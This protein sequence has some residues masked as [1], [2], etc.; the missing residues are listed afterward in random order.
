M[1]NFFNNVYFGNSIK[2]WTTALSILLLGVLITLFFKKR[3]LTCLKRW[4]S[5]SQT[6]LDDFLLATIETSVVPLFYVG[7]FSVAIKALSIPAGIGAV[8]HVAVLLFST[9]FV[10]KVITSIARQFVFSFIKSEDSDQIQAKQARGLILIINIVLWILGIIFL[11]DNLGYNVTTL[12]TGLGIGGIAVALAAQT[13][14]GDLFSYFSI[15]F[16]RPFEIG[17]FITVD[18]KAGTVEYIGIKTTRLRSLSGEQMVCSNTDLT[19]ARVHNYKRMEQRRVVFKLGVIYQT[20]VGRVKQIPGIIRDIIESKDLVRFDRGH[21]SGFGNFSLDFEFVY[22]VLSSE[23]NVYMDKQQEIF[24]DILS[25]FESRKIEFA[26]P[27]QT[28]IASIPLKEESPLDGVTDE[29][30]Y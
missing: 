18:D 3:I 30:N 26:Y 12:V 15:F 8:I 25:G 17:D 13:I 11:I 27:T 9:F 5:R 2:D 22:Y 4:A 16:D 28:I 21:F 7:A 24:F 19:N 10:L 23:Y 6:T 14:L 20:E 1:N 29:R